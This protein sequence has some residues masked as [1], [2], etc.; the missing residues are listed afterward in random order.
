MSSRKAGTGG[1]PYTLAHAEGP[2]TPS[3]PQLTVNKLS[4]RLFQ[5]SEPRAVVCAMVCAGSHR[6][7]RGHLRAPLRLHH[8][9]HS[10]GLLGGGGSLLPQCS[11]SLWSTANPLLWGEVGDPAVS[12]VSRVISGADSHLK[13]SGWPGG[14]RRQSPPPAGDARRAVSHHMHGPGQRCPV[15]RKDVCGARGL[16]DLAKGSNPGNSG[17]STGPECLSLTL[18]L[19]LG[20]SPQHR[21]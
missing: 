8:D 3:A 1:S 13:P 5:D 7:W 4:S 12:F 16:R 14:Q 11:Q 19:V 9:K 2:A 15:H 17:T 6:W 21:Q 20:S 18:S 10:S